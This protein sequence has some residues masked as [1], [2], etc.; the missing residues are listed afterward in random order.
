[1]DLSNASVARCW[2]KYFIDGM[3][4]TTYKMPFKSLRLFDEWRYKHPN[5]TVVQ[6]LIDYKYDEE[7]K[8]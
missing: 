6:L 8:S 4:Q 7:I 1:M 2:C 5:Y 3:P